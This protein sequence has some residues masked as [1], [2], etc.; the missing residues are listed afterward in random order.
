MTTEKKSPSAEPF[1]PSRIHKFMNWIDRLPGPY[2]LY[3]LGIIPIA[4]LLNH[5]VAWNE[6]VLAFGEINWYYALTAAFLAFYLFAI[7]FMFRIT[8]VSLAE[9]LP[10]LDIPED[11]CDRFMFQFTH[12]PAWPT[13][14]VFLLGA[15]VGLVI[16]LFVTPATPESNIAFPEFEIPINSL[17]FG[18][19]YI[20]AYMV[21]R[22]FTQTNKA[23]QCIRTINIYDLHSLYAMSSYSAWLLIFVILHTYLLFTLTPSLFEFAIYYSLIVIAITAVL[24]LLFFWFPTHRVNRMLVLEKRRLLKDVNQ[25]IENIFVIL[26]TRIDQQEFSRIVELREALQG[27]MVEKGFIES[28]RTWPWKPGTLTSLLTVGVLPLVIGLLSELISKLIAL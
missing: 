16:A 3:Y 12:L 20:A 8:Q 14:L 19:S 2:W 22:A 24:V 7:D 17:S 26:N 18:M 25:R 27:L 4:G 15:I 5:I 10:S 28:I 11:E 9:F 13:T 6:N 21:I 1:K 23:Y